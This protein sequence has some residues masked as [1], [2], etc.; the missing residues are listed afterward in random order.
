M[1]DDELQN[2]LKTRFNFSDRE[3]QLIAGNILETHAT[4]L[5]GAKQSKIIRD[6]EKF[7]QEFAY[8]FAALEQKH[9]NKSKSLK[10]KEKKKKQLDIFVSKDQA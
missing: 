6:L 2:F 10:A 8:D 1:T 9:S 3:S 7:I 4:V 5:S